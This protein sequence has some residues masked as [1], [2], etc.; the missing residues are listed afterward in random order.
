[1][2]PVLGCNF[3]RISGCGLHKFWWA[4]ERFLSLGMKKSPDHLF[5][6]IID[7][8]SFQINLDD[9]FIIDINWNCVKS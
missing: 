2:T 7:K 3:V 5:W 8:N 9:S 4:Y 1:M 6:K